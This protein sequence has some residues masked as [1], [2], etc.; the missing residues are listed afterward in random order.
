MYFTDTL[1]NKWRIPYQYRVRGINPFGE[2]GQ[3]SD[4]DK[5]DR[6]LTC[7]LFVP[8]AFNRLMQSDKGMLQMQ[9]V[10]EER[11]QTA[12]SRVSDLNRADNA[13]GPLRQNMA[14]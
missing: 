12:P 6:A 3:P 2:I 1:H 7:C 5:G 9:W 11:R 13:E 4:S 8:G 14:R 10:F